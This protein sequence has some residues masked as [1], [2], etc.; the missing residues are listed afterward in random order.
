MPQDDAIDSPSSPCP[1]PCDV[2]IPVVYPHQLIKIPGAEV[3]AQVPFEIDIAASMRATFTDPDSSPPLSIART[4]GRDVYVDGLGHA[5][6]AMINGRTGEVRYYEYGRYDPAEY[7]QVRQVPDVSNVTI[8]FGED[9]NPDRPSL[10]AL[11]QA[12]TR[13]NGR[14][15]FEGVYVKL[16][17]GAFDVMK[18]FAEARKAA[19]ASRS[20][21]EYNVSSNHCFTFAME[22]AASAGVVTSRARSA[23]T[24]DVELVGG[25]WATRGMIAGVAPDFEVPARQMRAL[26]GQ[27][28]AFNA[29]SSGTVDSDFDF[30][31]GLNAR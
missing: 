7:G 19:V 17:N 24:L 1:G 29:S 22:V 27:Y 30:P 15:A 21:A 23:P 2:A 31:S 9:G 4:S 16:A 20:A 28:R 5:G 25:N 12:L 3:D 14:Y 18:D 8:T 13:T 26:Q 11:A 6:I 10:D